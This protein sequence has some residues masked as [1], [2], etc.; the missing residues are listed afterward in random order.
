MHKYRLNN[1]ISGIIFALVISIIFIG[2]AVQGVIREEQIIFSKIKT[3]GK[4]QMIGSILGES[5][6]EWEDDFFDTS[7]IDDD[8]SYN[9]DID[10]VEGTVQMSNTYPAWDAYPEWERMKPISVHNSGD[11][12]LDDYVLDIT[13]P[14]DNDMQSDFDD[15]RF[16]DENS[17]PLTYW[18]GDVL[19]GGSAD[20]L[21]RIPELPAQQTITIYMFYGNPLVGD[22]S[23]DSIFTWSEIT[24]EDL[25]LS[26]TMQTEG[27]WDPDVAYGNSK[28]IAAWEEGGGP[29]FSPDHSHRLVQRQIHVRLL[30][31]DGENPIPEYPDDID[32]STTSS[33]NYHAE[34]PSISYS[35][36]SD[37]FL[38]V[39]E[40]NPTL[41]RYAVSI[42]G[43]YVTPTGVDYYPFTIW[44]PLYQDLQYYPNYDP[45]VA[46][47]EQSNRFFVVWSRSN[48][49]W[50]FDVYGAFY[51][52]NGGQIGDEIHIATGSYYQGQPWV[53]SDNLGHFLVV[54]EEGVSSSNG[55]FHVKGKLYEY[56]GDQIGDEIDIA[57][58]TSSIDNIFPSV[59]FNDISMKYLV[60]WNTGDASSSDYNGVINGLLLN[61][62]GDTLDSLTIQSGSVYKIS[63]GFPYLGERFFVTYDDDYYDVNAIW[64]RLVTSDGIVLSNRPE[65]SDDLDFD[66]GFANSCVGEGNVFVAWED[67]RL[68]L[69]LPPTEIRG[70]VWTCPQ[71]T[72]SE[73]VSYGFGNEAELILDSALVS[74]EII[75]EDLI[76]WTEFSAN[77]TYPESAAIDFDIMDGNGTTVLI[78]GISPGEDISSVTDDSIRIQARFSRDTPKNTSVLDIW[79]VTALIGSDIEPPWTNI[80]L[81]PSYPNGENGWY[82]SPIYIN[83]TAFDN[84]S[85]P[86]NVTTFYKINDGDVEE[87]DPGSIIV[88]STEGTDNS[89][90]YWSAD[91]AGNEELPHNIIEDIKID[92]SEP[93][94]T[95]VEPPDIV[96]PGE[97]T[98]NGTITE[99]SSGSGVDRMIIKIDNEQ[100]YNKTYNGEQSVFFETQFIAD[101][102]EIY[103]IYVESYDLAGNNAQ[104]QKT[105]TCSDR[106]LYETGCIYIF[107][108]PKIGPLPFLV[109]RGYAIAVDYDSLYITVPGIHE[110]ASSVKFAAKQKIL[111]HELTTWDNNVS[112]GVSCE[113]D[114]PLLGIYRITAS[115][116]DS[117]DVFLEE[118]LVIEQMLVIILS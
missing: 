88:L 8:L 59:S 80:T 81:D 82:I 11:D 50:N 96:Y 31:T 91:N 99:Y 90:E 13:I 95:I 38:V 16:A 107:D 21:V 84:D 65:L 55:P 67:E 53:C 15:I 14:Y 86:E 102:A 24:D 25:R 22:E 43:A 47:D 112:D 58:G 60:T 36:D 56:D 32:I 103:D 87:Y 106:G 118:Y 12:A 70:S 108:N 26:W 5:T 73:D 35:E 117:E 2:S 68:D 54:Y 40:E 115:A 116:Y 75:P 85:V 3:D 83:F 109:N 37:K 18:I 101:I 110:N 49:N 63:N 23:D 10:I 27:A 52:P 45:C 97:I 19:Y 51:W 4:N 71:S 48:T 46:Y 34:N 77:A 111:E 1:N 64:G 39:W 62:N 105:V 41:A 29:G 76:E 93:A 20:M 6:F 7:K 79:G 9:Y 89:I 78:E 42:K 74:V 44:E 72:G 113:F 98:I 33:N 104:D 92:I 17:F 57:T 66:K 114:L 69:Y 94:I 61:E 28:F 30:D 100:V